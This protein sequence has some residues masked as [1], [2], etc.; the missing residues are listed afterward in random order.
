MPNDLINPPLIARILGTHERLSWL[1][2]GVSAPDV[3]SVPESECAVA[4]RSVQELNNLAGET[5]AVWMDGEA[6]GGIRLTE[7]GRRL[8]VGHLALKAE[9]ERLLFHFGGHFADDLRLLE[10]I[11]V[12]TSARNQLVAR[13]HSVAKD[14]LQGE[15]VLELA[16]S[17]IIRAIVT[18]NSAVALGL[19]PGAEVIA[20][21]KASAVSIAFNANGARYRG[22]N[23]LRGRILDVLR[24]DEMAEVVVDLGTGLTVVAL[25]TEFMPGAY[26]IGASVTAVFDPA[27]VLIG[28]AS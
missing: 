19:T 23:K 1:M 15:V 3:L 8:C 5:L 14:K 9:Q 2:R 6:G 20:L 10:R 7:R 11:A 21:I 18:D 17:H 13:V 27:S 26:V 28:V 25:V 12:R 22:A 4:R 24:R 16:G